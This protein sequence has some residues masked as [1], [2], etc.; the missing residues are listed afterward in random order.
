MTMTA[1]LA[2]R[3]DEN[4]DRRREQTNRKADEWRDRRARFRDLLPS[5]GGVYAL[6]GEF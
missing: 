5:L 1:Q 3:D 2:L 6:G 4:Y